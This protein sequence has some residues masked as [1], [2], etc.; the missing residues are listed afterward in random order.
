MLGIGNFRLKHFSLRVA[1]GFAPF[2]VL[3]DIVIIS[4]LYEEYRYIGKVHMLS[5]GEGRISVRHPMCYSDTRPTVSMWKKQSEM[6]RK[7]YIL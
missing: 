2:F 1:E 7:F 3:R 6:A 5:L 4:F